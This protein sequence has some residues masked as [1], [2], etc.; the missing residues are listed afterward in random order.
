MTNG[1]QLALSVRTFADDGVAPFYIR[2]VL[3]L[4]PYSDIG[5]S[6]LNSCFFSDTPGNRWSSVSTQAMI[7]TCFQSVIC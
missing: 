2:K 7:A 3:G 5:Y 1:I 6:N 4:N